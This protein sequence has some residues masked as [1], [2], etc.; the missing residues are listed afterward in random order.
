MIADWFARLQKFVNDQDWPPLRF[1]KGLSERVIAKAEKKMKM[2]FPSQFKQYLT[3]ANGEILSGES[4]P[5]LPGCEPLAPLD[6]IIKGWND[7]TDNTEGKHINA[8]V[9]CNGKVKNYYYSDRRIPIAGG[10]LWN[11]SIVFI[12]LDP[13]PG[14]ELGQLIYRAKGGPF[15]W[16]DESLETAVS[17]WVQLLESGEWIFDSNLNNVRPKSRKKIIKPILLFSADPL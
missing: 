17:R 14:G 7:Q 13:G 4:F 10:P 8:N 16:I 1:N 3:H 5:W 9:L 2:E 11:D 6:D 15:T 12:D